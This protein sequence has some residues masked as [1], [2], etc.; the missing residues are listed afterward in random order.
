VPP[1]RAPQ[2][3]NHLRSGN[4]VQRCWSA[5]TKSQSYLH[6]RRG[7]SAAEPRAT[8]AE[9]S[10]LRQQRP[11]VLERSDKILKLLTFA[12]RPECRRA[13]RHKRITIY[14]RAMITGGVGA[15]RQNPKLLHFATRPECRRAARNKRITIYARAMIT[16]GLERS[17][18]IP[19][20]LNSRRGPSAAEPRA[21]SA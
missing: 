9:S 19:S 21:T 20:Y 14:A 11:A 16:G 8:S 18:K 1:S 7:P 13:A 3:Q 2:A 4:N 5:A 10:S 12:A 17:D 15:Q 6:S